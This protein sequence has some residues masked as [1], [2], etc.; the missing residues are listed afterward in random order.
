MIRAGSAVVTPRSVRQVSIQWPSALDHDRGVADGRSE[1]D[2]GRA[3]AERSAD[4]QARRARMMQ[5]V[6]LAQR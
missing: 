6:A 5:R 2:V 3:T 1:S 4:A